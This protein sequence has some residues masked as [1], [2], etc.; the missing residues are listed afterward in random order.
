M[1]ELFIFALVGLILLSPSVSAH[2]NLSIYSYG[3]DFIIWNVGGNTLIWLDGV[4]TAVSGLTYGQYDLSPGTE[5]IG[6]NI[7]GNCTGIVTKEN[8]YTVLLDWGIYFI[9]LAFCVISYF[10]PVTSFPAMVYGMY[11]LTVYLP[12][13]TSGDYL[14]YSLVAVLM[15]VAIVAAISGWRRLG[16]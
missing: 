11:L 15:V 13:N 4:E 8:S 12:E 7:D 2:G 3:D 10:I 1:K 5:H 14:S 9:M 6:C 16:R